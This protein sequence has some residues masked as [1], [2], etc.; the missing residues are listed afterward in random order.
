MKK[1]RVEEVVKEFYEWGVDSYD[2]D[3]VQAKAL[4]MGLVARLLNQQKGEG[5]VTFMVKKD[6]VI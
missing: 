6:G 3:T 4:V 5:T 2:G 1:E